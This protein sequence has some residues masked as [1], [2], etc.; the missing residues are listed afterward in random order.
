MS[1]SA[2][3][4]GQAGSDDLLAT[5]RRLDDE[6]YEAF[7]RGDTALAER[8]H[9]ESLELARECGDATAVAAALA[10]LMRL[11]LRSEDWSR[12]EQLCREGTAVALSCGDEALLRMPLHMSAES[13]RMR[14]DIDEARHRYRESIA[15]NQRLG[16]D[17]MVGVECGNL[18]WVE[19]E[20][21]DVDEARRL[22]DRC[23]RATEADDAYGMALVQLTRARLSLADGDPSGADLLRLATE[24]LEAAGLVWDPA[25]RRCFDETRAMT[26]PTAN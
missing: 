24:T 21:G 9:T 8:L 19:I 16:N 11:A 1:E 10:G 12:L 18:A 23:E 25:E 17:G 26:G 5:A 20:A 22:I 14:G 4:K 15:L 2:S 6:G 7:R 3:S 13:A